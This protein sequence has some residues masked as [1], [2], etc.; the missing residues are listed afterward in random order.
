[1]PNERPAV[2]IIVENLPVRIDRRVWQEA[3]ALGD[4]G[5]RVSIICPRDTR[6]PKSRETS[7][8]IEIYMRQS[9]IDGA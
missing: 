1:M 7:E 6:Y 8:N 3:R 4:A 9:S 5:Y 2:F